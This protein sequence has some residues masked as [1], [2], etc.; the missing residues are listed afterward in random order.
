MRALALLLLLVPASAALAQTPDTTASDADDLSEAEADPAPLPDPP[1]EEDS[2]D[3]PDIDVAADTIAPPPRESFEARVF[4]RVY[5]V[6]DP[7]AVTSL[8]AVNDASFY[9]FVAATP[10]TGAYELAAPDDGRPAIRM[11]ASELGTAGA[12]FLIK[13]LVRRPRPYAVLRNVHNRS[14]DDDPGGLDPYSFPSGHSATAFAI[15]TS[16]SLSAR[17]W[18]VTVPMMTWASATALA[19]VYHGVH[20]P[21]DIVVGAALGAGVATL[22]SVILPDGDGGELEEK[23]GPAVP[24]FSIRVGL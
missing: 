5:N 19:R 11:L 17:R 24:A 18:Y 15:A 6:D 20:Y 3:V 10:L 1:A 7:L 22:V 23:A 8:V 4:R 9:L 14:G 12:V 13:N 21:Y 16:T 2:V